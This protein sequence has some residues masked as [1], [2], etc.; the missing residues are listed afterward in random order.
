MRPRLLTAVPAV[1]LVLTFTGC[2]GDDAVMPPSPASI[3]NRT[4]DRLNPY[5]FTLTTDPA[6][7]SASGYTRI[8]VHVIDAEGMPAEG[9]NMEA[10]VSIGGMGERLQRIPLEDRG[11]GDYEADV[12]LNMPGSWGVNVIADKDGKHK[13]QRF[14]VDV[15]G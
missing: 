12:S 14:Y 15:G 9:V 1:L 10:D 7:P 3:I 5:R 4:R 8:Q 2:S 6:S 13:E 11:A